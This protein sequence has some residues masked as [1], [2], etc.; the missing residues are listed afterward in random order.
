MFNVL[1]AAEEE[2]CC[3]CTLVEGSICIDRIAD[4][5]LLQEHFMDEDGHLC[6]ARDGDNLVLYWIYGQIDSGAGTARE[7][8]QRPLGTFRPLTPLTS[9]C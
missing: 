6:K 3:T 9:I 2:W 5:S 8:A 4:L 7:C 1:A